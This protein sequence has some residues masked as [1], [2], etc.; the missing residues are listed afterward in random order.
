MYQL[1]PVLCS[2]SYKLGHFEM[3]V[4]GTTQMYSA[5]FPRNNKYLKQ[6]I[7]DAP[8]TLVVFGIQKAIVDIHELWQ[9]NFFK[10][11]WDFVLKNSLKVLTE[12]SNYTE[13]KF[14][15]QFKAL[16]SLGYLPI[17]IR[18]LPEGSICPLN[19]PILT[20]VNTDDRF[21][22]MSNF[23]EPLLLNT[24]YRPTTAATI[25]KAVA[26]LRNK[27]FEKTVVDNEGIDFAI[28]DFSFRGHPGAESAIQSSLAVL[29]YTKG[30]DTLAAVD[31]ARYYYGATKDVAYSI[32][33]TEHAITSQGIYFYSD[34]LVS[35]EK[36]ITV[37]EKN[38]ELVHVDFVKLG[39]E[40]KLPPENAEEIYTIAAQ[41]AK[42]TLVDNLGIGEL[43]NLYRLIKVKYPSGILAYVSD[44]FN[45]PRLVTE[46]LPRLKEII[47]ARDGKLVI[48]PDSGDPIININGI[49]TDKTPNRILY[50]QLRDL[51]KVKSATE[52]GCFSYKGVSYWK[53]K[54]LP[55]VK[56][57][58]YLSF[59]VLESQGYIVPFCSDTKDP[60]FNAMDNFFHKGAMPFIWDLFGGTVNSKGFKQL[61]SHIGF[62]YGDGMSYSRISQ[63]YKRMEE[64]GF[65]ANNICVAAG[66]Y[67]LSV[68][69]TR[70]S[71]GFAIKASNTIVDGTKEVRVNK[72]PIT[73]P[74]K[75]SPKG[76]LYV[77]PATF[78]LESE[79]T[80]EKSQEGALK[81]LYRNGKFNVS[82]LV[83]LDQ[84]REILK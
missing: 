58:W 50:E 62:V 4:E 36:Y 84:L 5:L 76:Y 13:E 28:H 48:R 44:T 6:V 78:K 19:I 57:G 81:R 68:A 73:D 79:V 71:L 82:N 39:A 21:P 9:E 38:P 61:D 3:M 20:I 63:M 60:E 7:P 37:D 16:H 27:A 51:V 56:D 22:W 77:E 18:A 64:N 42:D 29:L 31:A 2:D 75:A 40:Y 35:A 34:F 41:Y 67:L 83:F 10:K 12:H 15:N 32:H 25:M 65:A 80:W 45:F 52:S 30:T 1:K 70:D 33:A 47:M 23:L 8:D 72:D 69:I 59:G 43:V 14:T 74:G 11:S 26:N 53:V 55:D 46:I 17:E 66:A 49:K 24:I 54:E